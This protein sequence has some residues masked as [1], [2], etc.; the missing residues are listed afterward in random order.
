VRALLPCV[1][2]SLPLARPS[3][4][5]DEPE[6]SQYALTITSIVV[7]LRGTAQMIGEAARSEDTKTHEQRAIE[8]SRDR[9]WILREHMTW[10]KA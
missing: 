8:M 2:R 7:V 3:L 6:R 4:L 1:H 5:H 9:T 10:L